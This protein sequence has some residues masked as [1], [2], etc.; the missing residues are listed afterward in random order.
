VGVH[1]NEEIELVGI[2]KVT[3]A[4]RLVMQA[5]VA[6]LQASAETSFNGHTSG[7][8]REQYDDWPS[9][10]WLSVYM[11]DS[12]SG[13]TLHQAQLVLGWVTI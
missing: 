9:V 8:S 11:L 7:T 13:V 1:L 2:V 3:N 6:K 10:V 12:N 4:G 5:T